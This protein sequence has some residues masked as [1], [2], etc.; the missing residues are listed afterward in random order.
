MNKISFR[1]S[2]RLLFLTS[3]LVVG[4]GNKPTP[5]VALPLL[6][7]LIYSDSE[8]A[9]NRAECLRK[10]SFHVVRYYWKDMAVCY[11]FHGTEYLK[12]EDLKPIFRHIFGGHSGDKLFVI[13]DIRWDY[14][15]QSISIQKKMIEFELALCESGCKEI[16][17]FIP[18]PETGSYDVVSAPFENRI[19]FLRECLRLMAPDESKGTAPEK[20]KV[21]ADAE[22]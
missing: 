12:F 6:S 20:E 2:I 8:L 3:F 22:E 16:W 10:H 19:V 17:R 21:T 4:G 9:L 1:K 5:Q 11:E 15:K 13:S 7:P 14:S 18:E